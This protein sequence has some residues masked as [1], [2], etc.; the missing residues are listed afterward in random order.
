[1]LKKKK[2][3][4]DPATFSNGGHNNQKRKQKIGRKGAGRSRLGVDRQ[5]NIKH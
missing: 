1:M 2:H 3:V 4:E 5:Q